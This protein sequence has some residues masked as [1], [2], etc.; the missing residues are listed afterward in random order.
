MS[1]ID[2]LRKWSRRKKLLSVVVISCIGIIII[3]MVIGSF[4]PYK[5]TSTITGEIGS[6]STEVTK[7]WDEGTNKI[8]SDLPPGE[9]RFIQTSNFGGSF[10]RYSDSSM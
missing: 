5:N 7:V 2:D 8:A 3:A 4:F 9:Y 10:I 6:N 1:F